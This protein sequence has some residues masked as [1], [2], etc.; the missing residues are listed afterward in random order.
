VTSELSPEE[1]RVL[2]ALIEKWATTPDN[3]PLS[4]NALRLACN[5]TSNRDP[6]LAFDQR[7]VDAVMIELRQR[8]LARTVHQSGSRVPKHRHTVDEALG[9]ATGELAVMAVLLLRGPQTVAELATRTARYAGAPDGA[10]A[11]EAVIDRLATGD[12]PLVVRIGRRLGEREPRVAQVMT[13]AATAGDAAAPPNAAVP[14]AVSWPAG[15]EASPGAAVAEPPE[16]APLGIGDDLRNRVE[17]LE[18]ALAEQTAR[19]DRLADA[20]GDW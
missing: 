8:G 2:G 4:A 14:R 5:Q 1:A 20:L 11:V 10:P 15:R 16:P 6:V 13:G 18:R 3:Y 12:D 9:L 17:A 19:I 7:T